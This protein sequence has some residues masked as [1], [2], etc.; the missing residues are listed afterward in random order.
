M[1]SPL[2]H[3]GAFNVSTN[4]YRNSTYSGT[5][6]IGPSGSGQYLMMK[7]STSNAGV[8]YATTAAAGTSQPYGILQNKPGVG[9]VCDVGIFGLTNA[10]AGTTTITAGGDLMSDSSGCLIPYTSGAGVYRV[11][12][13]VGSVVPSAVGEQFTAFLFGGA[14]G[15]SVA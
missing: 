2:I 7:Q 13:Q 4:D 9:D 14:G 1:E 8:V 3:D 11:G 15:G 6:R 5:T 10:I 12:R